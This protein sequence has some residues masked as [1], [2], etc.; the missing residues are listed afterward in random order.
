[1]NAKY[2]HGGFAALHVFLRMEVTGNAS[3]APGFY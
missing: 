2:L 3:D 1:M